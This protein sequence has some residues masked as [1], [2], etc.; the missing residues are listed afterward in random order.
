MKIRNLF[1]SHSKNSCKKNIQSNPRRIITVETDSETLEIVNLKKV[2]IAKY[3]DIYELVYSDDIYEYNVI[4][5]WK[6][7][8]RTS[9]YRQL[10]NKL[11]EA[12]NNGDSF[13]E[14]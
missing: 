8:S 12:Y 11:I 5:W 2:W 6:R 7:A 13:V 4:Y 9:Y 3:L 14:L 1:K 10:K